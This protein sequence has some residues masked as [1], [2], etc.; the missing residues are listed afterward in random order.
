MPFVGLFLTIVASILIIP[1]GSD[2]FFVLSAGSK[3]VSLILLAF[4]WIIDIYFII[5]WFQSKEA[6]N[7]EDYNSNNYDEDSRPLNSFKIYEEFYDYLKKRKKADIIKIYN[8]LVKI[9][10]ELAKIPRLEFTMKKSMTLTKKT[11]KKEEI[12][13]MVWNLLKWI[14]SNVLKEKSSTNS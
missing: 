14:R 5:K 2:W 7:T 12:I 13:K 11:P 10:N 1:S 3:T 9:Y 4:F 8:E 6:V